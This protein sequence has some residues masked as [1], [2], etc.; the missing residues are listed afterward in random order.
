MTISP[1]EW[2][3]RGK[4]E[5]G[6]MDKDL[7]LYKL[8]QGFFDYFAQRVRDGAVDPMRGGEIALVRLVFVWLRG[9]RQAEAVSLGECSGGSVVWAE[10]F[11][12][13]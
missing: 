5:W 13:Q 6:E 4:G 8:E 12:D 11:R 2:G 7:D 10:R 9:Q 3:L 1:C